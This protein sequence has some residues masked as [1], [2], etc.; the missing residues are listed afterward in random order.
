MIY[1]QL[2]DLLMKQGVKP[3]EIK[4]KKFDPNYHQAFIIEESNDVDEPEVSQELQKGYLLHDRLIRP[5]LV[6][7]IMPK[8]EQS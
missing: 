8:K 7:V 6:K 5:S 4:D 1:K 3:I 2:L